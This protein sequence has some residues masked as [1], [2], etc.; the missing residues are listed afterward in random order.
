MVSG[1][2]FSDS[3]IS[4]SENGCRIK[5]N[6]DTTGTIENIIYKNI[7]MF[8]ISDYGIDVQQ[9]YLNGGATGDPTN[10]VIISGVTFDNVTGTVASDAYNYYILCGSDSCSAFIFTDVAISGGGESSSCNFPSSGCPS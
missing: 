4:N 8:N 6:A 3:T 9:D 7:V 5:S 2:I 10:G 1:V